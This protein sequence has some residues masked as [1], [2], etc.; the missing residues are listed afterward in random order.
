MYA[1]ATLSILEARTLMPSTCCPKCGFSLS[2]SPEH[3]GQK[4]AC[5]RCGQRIVLAD[6]TAGN[7]PQSRA[8]QVLESQREQSQAD[9]RFKKKLL[10][11]AGLLGAA[12]LIVASLWWITR[13]TW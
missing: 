5:K 2:Y 4:I 10:V 12:A 6:D 9:A 1:R 3:V 8:A 13:D 7:E 11:S